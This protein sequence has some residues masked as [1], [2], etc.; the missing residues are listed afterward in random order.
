MKW[1]KWNEMKWNEMKQIKSEIKWKN[2]KNEMFN[3]RNEMKKR[4]R[5]IWEVKN[6]MK[7]SEMKMK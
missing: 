4:I 6:E 1:N 3:K 5:K 2:G 7:G